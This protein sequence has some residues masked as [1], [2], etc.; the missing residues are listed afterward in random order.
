MDA[1]TWDETLNRG[2]FVILDVAMGGAPP[3]ADG[4]TP[5]P[6]TEPGHPKRA[7]RVTVSSREGAPREGAS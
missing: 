1:A 4:A 2:Q 7:A 3:A 5:G 6:A